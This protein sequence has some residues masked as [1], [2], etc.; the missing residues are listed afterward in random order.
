MGDMGSTMTGTWNSSHLEAHRQLT[1]YQVNG[2]K[3]QRKKVKGRVIV[4]KHD[5]NTLMPNPDSICCLTCSERLV[6]CC[7]E[8]DSCVAARQGRFK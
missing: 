6:G 2:E 3:T 7:L 4:L 5:S 1:R 8:C